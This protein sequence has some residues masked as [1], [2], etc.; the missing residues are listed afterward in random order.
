[1]RTAGV[2]A[3]FALL[4]ASPALAGT[5]GGQPCTW[6]N[7]WYHTRPYNSVDTDLG[8]QNPDGSPLPD[9]GGSTGIQMNDPHSGTLFSVTANHVLDPPDHSS[10]PV[11]QPYYN[12]SLFGNPAPP[13]GGG[14]CEIGTVLN[15]G[16]S[17]L[18]QP[19]NQN[20]SDMGLVLLFGGG[21]V[22]NGLVGFPGRTLSVHQAC[23]TLAIQS[24]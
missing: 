7:A 24:A 4:C 10:Y 23:R 12:Q 6:P 2:A 22:N 11:N 9:C 14:A 1:M 16:P 20:D 18:C 15:A 5:C 19:T 13:C 17:L 8:V 21:E 3:L